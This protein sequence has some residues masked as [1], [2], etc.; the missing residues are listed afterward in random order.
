MPFGNDYVETE[1]TINGFIMPVWS[2]TV[3]SSCCNAIDTAI[4]LIKNIGNFTEKIKKF[5]EVQ[6][7]A[8]F[9]DEGIWVVYNGYVDTVDGTSTLLVK[10]KDFIWKIDQLETNRISATFA[11]TTPADILSRLFA[12]SN[13]DKKNT[14]LDEQ[15]FNPVTTFS[16]NGESFIAAIRKINRIWKIDSLLYV[17]HDNDDIPIVYWGEDPDDKNDTDRLLNEQDVLLQGREVVSAFWNSNTKKGKINTRYP[18]FHLR[19]SDTFNLFSQEVPNDR[20]KIE[21]IE[22]RIDNITGTQT[23]PPYS[24][25]WFGEDVERKIAEDLGLSSKLL[26]KQ[27]RQP[28]PLVPD[29]ET[30]STQIVDVF[31]DTNK[32]DVTLPATATTTS[33]I[34]LTKENERIVKRLLR[35]NL[36]NPKSKLKV[37]LL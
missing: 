15:G 12:T 18:L 6:I 23:R 10:C 25:I 35:S 14:R 17:R 16:L 28:L 27:T 26:F 21:R 5:D 7:K 33:T 30:D 37:K 3:K 13:I 32:L 4:I 29:G 34:K 9:L 19:H 11:S 20:Y 24:A 36:N 1:V 2:F 22:H 8:G 31:T